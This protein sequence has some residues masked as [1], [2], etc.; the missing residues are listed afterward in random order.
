VH[1]CQKVSFVFASFQA[2]AAPRP[3]ISDSDEKDA[4]F[5]RDTQITTYRVILNE[6][7][8]FHRLVILLLVILLFNVIVDINI[9]VLAYLTQFINT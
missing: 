2:S 1:L 9:G 6:S 7:D 8:F 5:A 4:L 3:E